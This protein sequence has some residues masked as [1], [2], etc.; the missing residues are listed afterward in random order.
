MSSAKKRVKKSPLPSPSLKS[1]K[2]SV[3]DDQ[4]YGFP[5]AGDT[6]R[7]LLESSDRLDSR[8]RAFMD[9]A[10]EENAARIS[11]RGDFVRA[12]V[13]THGVSMESRRRL[14][15]A[16]SGAD[17][18]RGRSTTSYHEAVTRA[19][20]RKD[21][22]ETCFAQIEL[23]LSR[24]FPE[25]EDFGEEGRMIEPLR[26]VLRATAS[27][28]SLSSGYVQGMNFLA[29]FLL[30]V[31]ANEEDA[32]W[33]LRC[34][35]EDMFPGFYD[36]GLGQ[37]RADLDT[38]DFRF[39]RV[40]S[41]AHAKLTD[42]GLAVKYF[43]ARWLICCLIGCAPIPLLTRVWDLLFVDADRKPR[44]TI[45]RCSL[46]ILALQAPFIQA[47]EEMGASVEC[48]RM[49]G[50]N[51]DNIDAFLQRVS[52]LRETNFPTARPAE[53][54][55]ALATPAKKRAK[56]HAP[57]PTA[58]RVAMTPVGN[59]TWANLVAF[60]TPTPM[61]TVQTQ[62]K[63]QGRGLA[64]PSVRAMSVKP[65]RLWN[66]EASPRNTPPPSTV[67]R[68]QFGDE[69]VNDPPAIEMS[70]LRKSAS[71]RK[72]DDGGYANSPLFAKSPLLRSPLFTNSPMRTQLSAMR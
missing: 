11:R 38:L 28:V 52:D 21:L 2:A 31:M 53:E 23:D 59:S 64:T 45:L 17:A 49:A 4:W 24:T 51:I 57:P 68:V 6:N 36:A 14:W 39:S 37:L 67:R 1:S 62:A 10:D 32:Y 43:T 7:R 41:E 5:R 63:S 20:N 30:V 48:I 25:R 16:W 22:E 13:R 60:F 56:F 40:A 12:F 26:R 42:A 66:F 19:E 9:T 15:K 34:V 3:S 71:K 47:A 65:T 8:C 54:E 27:S 61:K 50:N 58:A 33:V 44:E 46:A 70:E 69:N 29:G 72:R 55:S 35:V 18:K